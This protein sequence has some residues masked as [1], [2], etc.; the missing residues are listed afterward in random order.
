MCYRSLKNIYQVELLL[1]ICFISWDVIFIYLIVYYHVINA[2]NMGQIFRNHNNYNYCIIL[3]CLIKVIFSF[4]INPKCFIAASKLLL[5]AWIE[6]RC[7][8]VVTRHWMWKCVFFFLGSEFYHKLR[9]T[10]PGESHRGHKEFGP[11]NS[12][13][14]AE[15]WTH[16]CFHPPE[17]QQPAKSVSNYMNPIDVLC[18]AKLWE[19]SVVLLCWDNR[20]W[21]MGRPQVLCCVNDNRQ[22][23]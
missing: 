13:M 1:C 23:L 20:N 3:L 15:A 22:I 9:L 18:S 7:V 5:Q 8:L 16:Q 2:C 4:I 14:L 21:S 11:V 12:P 17:V 19:M 6:V 10:G